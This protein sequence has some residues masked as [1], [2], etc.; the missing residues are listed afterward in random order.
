[1]YKKPTNLKKIQLIDLWAKKSFTVVKEGMKIYFLYIIF[2]F[3]ISWSNA[4]VIN[5][6]QMKG[7][8]EFQMKQ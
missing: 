3:I 1:M 7:I 8:R 2:C 5:K 4:E 6:I